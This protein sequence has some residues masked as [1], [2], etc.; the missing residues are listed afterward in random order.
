MRSETSPNSDPDTTPNPNSIYT[1]IKRIE[2]VPHT[3][4]WGNTYQERS[5]SFTLWTLFPTI[6]LMFWHF[7]WDL[8]YFSFE[9]WNRRTIATLNPDHRTHNPN[10]DSIFRKEWMNFVPSHT[11]CCENTYILLIY[12]N[13]F[14]NYQELLLLTGTYFIFYF[15]SNIL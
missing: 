5:F 3:V 9:N 15:I 4:C 14:R 11:A 12:T 13:I 6:Y 10:P 1:I 2:F 7:S 8:A